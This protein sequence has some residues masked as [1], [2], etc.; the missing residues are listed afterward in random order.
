LGGRILALVIAAAALA[1]FAAG[2]GEIT[3]DEAPDGL[4]RGRPD[5]AA[6]G[7]TGGAGAGGGIDG[8]GGARAAGT[9]GAAT[10]GTGGAGLSGA[11]GGPGTG[12]ALA[13]GGGGANAAGGTAGAAA[14]PPAR[15]STPLKVTPPAACPGGTSRGGLPCFSCEFGTGTPDVDRDCARSSGTVSCDAHGCTAHVD[16]LCVLDCGSCS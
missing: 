9:G 5:V 16:Q 13:A 15:C 7:G 3:S 10:F 4:V 8:A 14:P 6:A 12:G 2:C 11:P 1:L